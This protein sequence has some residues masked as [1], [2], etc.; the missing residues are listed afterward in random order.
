ML[1]G[2]LIKITKEHPYDPKTGAEQE[3]LYKV[4]KYNLNR[5]SKKLCHK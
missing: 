1:I 4:E 3:V 2:E 5:G